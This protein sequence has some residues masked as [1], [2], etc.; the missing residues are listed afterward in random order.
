M[1]NSKVNREL[2][3]EMKM[4]AMGKLLGRPTKESQTGEYQVQLANT[5]GW[6]N[7]IGVTFG[8]GKRVYRINNIGSEH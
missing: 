7:K 5:V 2:V 1:T 3:K 6:R 4:Q 8:I